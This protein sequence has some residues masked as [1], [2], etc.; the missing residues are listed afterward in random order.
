[1]SD[2][3]RNR[4]VLIFVIG[5][6]AVSVVVSATRKTHLGLDLKG[7]TE[8]IFQARPGANTKVD[9]QSIANAINIIRSRIDKLGVSEPIITQTGSDEISVS[10]PNVKNAAQAQAQVGKTGQLYFYNW[11]ASVIAANGKPAGPN[12]Q[13]STGD[14]QFPGQSGY[15]TEYQAVT[16]G[17][18]T[19][20]M[21]AVMKVT[22]LASTIAA[23]PRR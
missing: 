7:G 9:S 23:K 5:L 20:R 8:L 12:D 1:M 11:E 15:L 4:F 22:T 6:A 2:R 3:L 21:K 19:K 10:L 13:A 17:E 14:N 16:R 18:R